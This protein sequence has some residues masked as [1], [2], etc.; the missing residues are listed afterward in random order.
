MLGVCLAYDL[1]V[2]CDEGPWSLFVILKQ[3]VVDALRREDTS[4]KRWV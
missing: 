3:M 2:A 1:F 4:K